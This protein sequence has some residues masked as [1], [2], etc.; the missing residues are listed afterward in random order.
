MSTKKE[1][2]RKKMKTNQKATKT[3][4]SNKVK[5]AAAIAALTTIILMYKGSSEN[6][7]IQKQATAFRN[8]L[9]G[10][11]DADVKGLSPKD[12]SY[13]AQIYLFITSYIPNWTR[14]NP[15]VGLGQFKDWFT[16]KN[17]KAVV[18]KTEKTD[19][20]FKQEDKEERGLRKNMRQQKID[21]RAIQKRVINAA[22]ERV[23]ND[24]RN[25]FER[26]QAKVAKDRVINDARNKFEREQAKVAKDRVINDARNKFER[27]Q[28][29]AAEEKFM[30]EQAVAE[31]AAVARA[32][33]EEQVAAEAQAAVE[34]AA[35]KEAYA[36]DAVEAA[37]AKEA[38]QNAMNLD[39]FKARRDQ[40]TNRQQVSA[41]DRPIAEPIVPFKP[42]SIY[43]FDRL[44]KPVAIDPG[45]STFLKYT[46][47]LTEA[48]L[49]A[50]REEAFRLYANARKKGG[51][52][53]RRTKRFSRYN[54]RSA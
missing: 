12:Q 48:Q 41:A 24:A 20:E 25:E 40:P 2:S 34:A 29:T 15:I 31:A 8:W 36:D 27:E 1:K 35:A 53:S 9:Q 52:R 11:T 22:E 13:F 18:T 6:N 32:V 26:E 4:Y 47:P 30:Q 44:P 43:N 28:A 3:G 42:H 39:L 5:I 51:R 7:I 38:R 33:A 23:I 17:A 21:E 14:Y 54:S 50:Q 37:A 19:A 45:S 49:E 46:K 16:R 10:I